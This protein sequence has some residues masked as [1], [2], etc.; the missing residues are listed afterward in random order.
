MSRVA[1]PQAAHV[2]VET[3]EEDV[4]VLAGKARRA[5][6]EVG[7]VDYALLDS[8]AREGLV[9]GYAA[10][11]NGLTF[12]IQIVM[13]ATPPD[14]DRHLAELDAHVQRPENALIEDLAIEQVDLTHR[15]ARSHP[16]LTRR[17][18]LVVPADGDAAAAS[19]LGL[20]RRRGDSPRDAGARARRQLTFRCDELARQ[21]GRCDLTARRLDA[22]ELL[23]LLYACWCPEL[24]RTQRLRR[25]L[26]D[27]TA[28]VVTGARAA[29][30]GPTA[31]SRARGSGTA[32]R[33]ESRETPGPWGAGR[34]VAPDVARFALGARSPADLIAPAAVEVGRDWLRLDREYARTLAVV[35]YPRS[36]GPGWL[37]P[38]I[39]FEEP[40]ELSLHIHPLETGQVVRSLT[41]KLV[42]LQSSRLLDDRKGRLADPEREVAYQDA[43]RLREALQRG[44]ERVFAV[45]LY[46]L[47]R[48]PTLEALDDL[49]GRLE[50]TLKGMLAQSRV[51]TL[52][53]AGGFRSVLPVGQDRLRRYRNLD[54]S[55]LALGF[56]F[57]AGTLTME[58]GVLYGLAPHTHSL[59]IV[60]PFDERLENANTVVFATSGAGK[61]YFTKLLALRNLL[62]GVEF[63]V[64]DPE[65]EYRALCEAVGGQYISLALTS[66][67]AINPLDLPPPADAG[68]DEA[69]RD[70]LAEAVAA[71]GGLLELML[72]EEGGR[73]TTQERAVLDRALYRAYADAGITAGDPDSWSRPAPT[74]FDLS[75]VLLDVPGATALDLV[76]R[77][78]RYVTGSLAGL[79]D[80]PTNVA[81]DRRFVVFNLQALPAE[82]RPLATHLIATFVWGQVRRARRPRLLV[83]DEAWSLL[84]HEA[85]GRFLAAMAR[86]ARKYHL[87]L[88][89][90]TQDV[91]DFLGSAHGRTILGNAAIKLALKQDSTTIDPV[92]AA[93]NLS[94]EER[95]YLLAAG[96]G[97]GLF[98]ARGGRVA[99]QVEA[100]ATE[101]RLATTAPRELAALAAVP[102]PAPASRATQDGP[103]SVPQHP[104]GVRH[105]T[106]DR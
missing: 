22:G 34:G 9:A 76:E 79:F 29:A 86:R 23:Q 25:D 67:Q 100:S 1:S 12:P 27:Y 63:I 88:V 6:L 35:N 99:L 81:L 17:F 103:L 51:A 30:A 57:A 68:D 20:L 77:L 105:A 70:P 2:A 61:S 15:L 43:E 55:S 74:L 44:E 78:D 53:Q 41:H 92:V 89:T 94:A 50:R 39:G 33:A 58:R 71:A 32:S 93:L 56:P 26:A 21:L 72:A 46:V 97:E 73:L 54:T 104:K 75:S 106:R 3:L 95:R 90:I 36:V 40:L 7:S 48:A 91:A 10:L 45:S 11:L 102:R 82:L 31:L 18:Y 49:T 5:V 42:Q 28:L 16:L 62:A 101:H 85:G 87:G 65:D 80:R 8:A 60:D 14:L 84:Q 59:V 13:R 66:A 96:K 24:A 47:L 37:A 4:L 98:F 52:E 19:P 64:I 83:V 38:L 69:A